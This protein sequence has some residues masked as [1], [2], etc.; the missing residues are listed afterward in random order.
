[1]DTTVTPGTHFV[2][3]H[4]YCNACAHNTNKDEDIDICDE[5]LKNPARYDGSRKPVCYLK[6]ET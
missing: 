2:D 1:M 6:K 4:S 5:C 3:Y